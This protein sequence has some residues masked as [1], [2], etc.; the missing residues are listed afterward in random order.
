MNR[1]V[2]HFM[3]MR[4][5]MQMSNRT[6]SISSTSAKRAQTAGFAGLCLSLLLNSAL[7]AAANV[8]PGGTG[9]SFGKNHAYILKAPAGWTL[10]TDA[11]AEQNLLAVFYPDGSD[12]DGPVA[13]YSEADAREGMTLDA[14]IQADIADMKKESPS[15]KVSDGGTAQTG[16]GKT[17]TVKYF[18]GDK[19][20]NFEAVG[21]VLEKNVVINI[22]LTARTK[23]QLDGALPTFRKLVSSYKY[24]TDNPQ[25]ADLKALAKAAGAKPTPGAEADSGGTGS[26]AGTTTPARSGSTGSGSTGTTSA[27]TT[28][29]AVGK[30][31][32]KDDF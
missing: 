32:T 6:N 4:V 16:D 13:M 8:I 19:D 11:G 21:Y 15:L 28:K 23:A 9:I 26:G 17:A 30:P 27:T 12:W 25:G 14:A 22:I 5:Q 10:D 18:S 24:L 3:L 29:P 20:G 7:P 2:I 31:V 1:V